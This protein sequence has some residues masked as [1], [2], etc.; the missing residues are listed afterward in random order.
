[1]SLQYC[2]SRSIRL[3]QYHLRSRSGMVA[4][5]ISNSC[6]CEQYKNYL[7]TIILS[8]SETATSIANDTFKC[9]IL[10]DEIDESE[11][12]INHNLIRFWFKYLSRT[13]LFENGW[14]LLLKMCRG[15]SVEFMTNPNISYIRKLFRY[16]LIQDP[17]GILHR[18][19]EWI[20]QV[21]HLLVSA[22]NSPS[23]E[24]RDELISFAN[25]MITVIVNCGTIIKTPHTEELY[26]FSKNLKEYATMYSL[27]IYNTERK[28]R[29][30]LLGLMP[31][32]ELED[33]KDDDIYQDIQN[34]VS[35][36]K[37]KEGMRPKKKL[38]V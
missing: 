23:K 36:E 31:I 4:C 38:V 35:L 18:E 27:P 10:S 20:V 22:Q 9:L 34:Q 33:G 7:W 1:M 11:N 32:K 16:M 29:Y 37:K 12:L 21:T 14:K 3:D 26:N 24:V 5:L 25:H 30:E 8:T 6:T 13:T 2:V 15:N 17:G 19:E 28:A